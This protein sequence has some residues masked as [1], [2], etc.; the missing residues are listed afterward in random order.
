MIRF[1]LGK[2]AYLIPTFLGITIVAFG[3]VRLL[4]GDPVLLPG[5]RT[6]HHA[7]ASR[8][9]LGPA[10]LRPTHLGAVFRLPREPVSGRLR[11]VA[12]HQETRPDRVP[13]AVP[14]DGR[15][16]TGGGHARHADR[17]SAGRLRRH[18]ARQLV[19]PDLDGHGAGGLFDA[20]LLVGAAAH[21]LL[22]GH[23][24][25]DPRSRGESTCSTSSRTAPASCCGIRSFRGRRA[26]SSRRCAT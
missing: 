15:A 1:L 21:H 12:D 25:M 17:H 10:R 14:G 11:P 19:R 4:P 2:L 8:R 16:R 24:E 9:T 20:D 7:R 13:D 5:G 3:F 26:P 22:L 18:Q 23:P 6:R